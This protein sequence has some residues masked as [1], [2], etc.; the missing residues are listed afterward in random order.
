M[1]EVTNLR[2]H[3]EDKNMIASIKDGYAR[4]Q[5]WRGILSEPKNF[6]KF[7]IV[8][9]L[10]FRLADSGDPLLMLPDAAHRGE[11]I[12]GIAIEHAHGI[13]GHLGSKKTLDYV[14]KHYWWSSMSKDIEKFCTSCGKCQTTKKSKLKYPGLLHQLP[15]PEKPWTSL[16]MDFVGPFPMSLSYNYLW[17]VMCCLTCQVHLVPVTTQV[18]TIDLA[19]LFLQHVVCLHGMPISIVSRSPLSSG[20]SYI[21]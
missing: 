18:K 19:H 21:G 7:S 17:V 3:V 1:P 20:L 8:D 15:I 11:K 14:H 9:G 2:P 4:H 12:I 6:P 13:L 16:V 10:I 5:A